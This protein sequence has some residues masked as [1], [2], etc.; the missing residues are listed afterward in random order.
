[1]KKRK[2]EVEG[3]K[4]SIDV[5][6]DY[7]NLTD[8]ARQSDRDEP[9]FLIMYWLQNSNTLEFLTAWENLHNPDFLKGGDIPTFRNKYTS[10]RKALTPQRYIQETG[11]IGLISKSGRYGGTFAHRDIAL[12]FSYWLS[13]T[14]QVYLLQEFQRLKEEEFKRLDSNRTWH[15]SKI[16]DYVDNARV[17]LD[18]IPGQLPENVRIEEEE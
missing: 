12:N 13:P 2:I 5:D 17:L 15:I 18:S 1:M 10:N 7:I 16:T 9:R 14:F 11:A 3:I 6:K 4:I 8:I